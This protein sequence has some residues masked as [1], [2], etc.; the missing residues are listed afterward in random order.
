M[1]DC[2]AG[3]RVRS[4]WSCCR[5][6]PAMPPSGQ[7]AGSDEKRC[8]H[9]GSSHS[10]HRWRFHP[11]S[12]QRLCNACAQYADNHGGQLPPDSVLQRRPAQP[13]RMADVREEI[14]QRRCLQCGSASP[15]GGK[16]AHWRSHPATGEGWLC[17]PCCG[18][19]YDQ[20]MGRT[21]HRKKR[22]KDQWQQ[23]GAQPAAQQSM[24][25]SD[26]A[27]LPEGKQAPTHIPTVNRKRRREQQGPAAAAPAAFH[28][29]PSGAAKQRG[30]AKQQP[31]VGSS[32][33]AAGLGLLDA[34]AGSCG[35]AR[36]PA[37]RRQ[38]RKQ[39]Q[40]QHLPPQSQA[41]TEQDASLAPTELVE[42]AVEEAAA[43]SLQGTI[44]AA[45]AAAPEAAVAAAAPA[46][47]A[48]QGDLHNA[49]AA[50][51]RQ[52][53]PAMQAGGQQLQSEPAAGGAS[54]FELL[55]EATE[56]AAAAAA[57]LTPELAA[58]FMMLLPL[59][60]QKVSGMLSFVL[61]AVTS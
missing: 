53:A 40:P 48:G 19:I 29:G 60:G 7:P 57:G 36:P 24:S 33:T 56:V 42:G 6:P 3:V 46:P 58:A 38:R 59:D 22:Q 39:A 32:G 15:G 2:S 50:P 12:G 49:A 41:A 8:T 45:I 13:R 52:Q 34:A 20:L 25:S 18:R 27:C 51:P 14:A 11:T 5:R 26:G 55:Q 23:E 9:C 37:Q 16:W 44:A 31:A 35:K 43:V 61:A 47:A 10:L 54:T 30:G 4:S 17:G 1:R 21:S 28:A